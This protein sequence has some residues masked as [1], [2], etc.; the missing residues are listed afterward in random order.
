VE[1]NEEVLERVEKNAVFARYA[2]L[3]VK[4]GL[5]SDMAGALGQLQKTVVRCTYPELIGRRLIEVRFTSKP[6]ERFPLDSKAV[7]YRYAEGAVTRLSGAKVQAVDVNADFLAESSEEWTREFAEDATWNVMEHAVEKVGRALGVEETVKVISLYESVQDE[8][9]AGG[10]ALDQGGKAMD[11]NAVSKL[12][13]AVREENWRP[14]VLVLN[15]TQLSQLLLDNK[16][17]EYEYL[18]SEGVDLEL[19]LVRR[20]IGMKVE[21]STLVPKG[22]AYAINTHVAGIMLIRRDVTV[23][24]WSGPLAN[25]YGVKATTRF[26]LGILRSNAIAKMT[27][28]KTTL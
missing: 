19:G 8:D 27:N 15:N 9:L 1:L 3:G 21:S 25:R 6:M 10:E 7:G 24:E 20:A 4:E 16:F 28:I 26:G 14:N 17:I 23:E 5:F 18:P 22:T 11:W 2:E 12:H 13:N